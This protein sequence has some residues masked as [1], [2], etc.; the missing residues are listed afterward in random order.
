MSTT[1]HSG[2]LG[3]PVS[4]QAVDVANP[5]L[6]RR[7]ME[8]VMVHLVSSQFLEAYG[9][10]DKVSLPMCGKDGVTDGP[11]VTWKLLNKLRDAQGGRIDKGQWVQQVTRPSGPHLP[12]GCYKYTDG[13]RTI[14]GAALK[15]F[16]SIITDRYKKGTKLF[17][18]VLNNLKVDN[19]VLHN[20]CVQVVDDSIGGGALRLY[21]F[22]PGRQEL[23]PGDVKG[24]ETHVEVS[25]CTIINYALKTY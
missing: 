9:S 15:A 24:R 1:T 13:P 25:N 17:I 5:D 22:G 4:Y 6:Y 16:T 19:D 20:G 12:N 10:N 8:K 23:F 11:Q 7:G 2:V 21:I 14:K 3:N 18:P